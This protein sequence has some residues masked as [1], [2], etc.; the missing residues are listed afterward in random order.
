MLS[1]KE[2][3]ESIASLGVE[4]NQIND[5]D[6]LLEHV[7]LRA[8][9]WV[10]ADAGSIYISDG[11]NL[12]FEYTQNETLQ[13][14]LSEGE[15]L[16]YSTF[17]IPINDK[18]ISGYVAL[19]GDSLNLSDVYNIPP[20][21]S[22]H[23][24][25]NIDDAAGYKTTSMLTIP[26]KRA[27]GDVIGVL[28]I[29]NA[30]DGNDKVISFTKDDE[31][32]MHHFAGIAAIALERAKMTRSIIMRMISM[33][34]LH[35]PKETGVHVN[36]VGSYA[37]EIYEHWARRRKIPKEEV[38]RNRD[39]LRMAAMLHDVGKIATSD[40]ILKKPGRLSEEEFEIMK[41]HTVHGARLFL[42]K[43]SEFDEAAGSVALNHHERWDGGGRGYPGHVEVETGDSI[44]DEAENSFRAK[45]KKGEEIPLFGRIVA[46]A[47]VYDA[48]SSA[49]CY[50]EAWDEEKILAIIKEESGKQF[51]PE[52]VEI[53]L[54]I[55]DT[56][57]SIE[58]RYSS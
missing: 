3:L 50:K 46:L 36:R 45:S 17:T 28:Q 44:M 13:S 32:I 26:L 11:K 24:S 12:K 27:K 58:E 7:L 38:D 18:S 57:K 37:V 48:L 51:D 42:D 47:D 49:R 15:K 53:F 14:R 30:K 1:E 52:L 54:E 41:K 56:I 33:A 4:L 39:V 8:R 25:C 21:V 40:L 2:K 6:I 22:Y 5:L 19:T 9:Q 35:D 31:K 16:I 34:E 23:F 10:N 55:F 29:I 20:D 43:Q